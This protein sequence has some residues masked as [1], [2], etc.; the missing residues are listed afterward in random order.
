MAE[1][2]F[3]K[4]QLEQRSKHEEIRR[5]HTIRPFP[6]HDCGWGEIIQSLCH[7]EQNKNKL[8]RVAFY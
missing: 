4:I 5:T 8:F 3:R 1:S 2:E 7:S 6:G